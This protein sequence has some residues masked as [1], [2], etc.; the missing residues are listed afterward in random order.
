[1]FNPSLKFKFLAIFLTI[2]FISEIILLVLVSYVGHESLFETFFLNLLLLLMI[3]GVLGFIF[4]L[5]KYFNKSVEEIHSLTRQKEAL[6]L[7]ALVSETNCEGMITYVNE[8]FCKTSQYTEQELLGKS[9]NIIN[10]GTH[11]KEFWHDFWTS[12]KSGNVWNGDICNQAKDGSL[13]WVNATISP[14]YNSH[15]DLIGYSAIRIDITQSKLIDQQTKERRSQVSLYNRKLAEL[16]RHPDFI[17]NNFQ[18]MLSTL[19][20]MVSEVTLVSRVSVWKLHETLDGKSLEC[21]S[22][23]IRAEQEHSKGIEIK[24]SKYPKYFKAL[25]EN[26]TLSC[27][28]VYS[29]PRIEEFTEDYFPAFEITSMLDA[30]FHF[31]GEL[32]GVL[33]LEHTSSERKWKVEEEAF[34]ISVADI[35]SIIF[36]SSKR[37]D[38]EAALRHSEKL[39]ALGKLTGGIAH[40][41]N[42]LLGVIMGYSALLEESIKEHPRLLKYAHQINIASQRGSKLTKNLLSFSR[43]KD[44]EARQTDINLVLQNQMDMLQKTLT[45]R[46]NLDVDLMEDLWPVFLDRN[47]LENAILNISINSMHAM[48]DIGVDA[49]LMISTQNKVINS[50]EASSLELKPG[51]HVILTFND[52][53]LGMNKQ[54]ISKIFDPFFS[55]K[56][57]KGT[58]IG[59]SQVF[60]FIKRSSGTIKVTSQLGK[61][62]KFSLYF[63]RF[64]EQENELNEI[65]DDD[66]LQ[67]TGNESILVVDDEKALRL[68]MSE[69]LSQQGYDVFNAESASS[70]LKIIDE[71]D[72]KLVVTDI[73]MPKMDGYELAAELAETYPAIKIQL[74]SGFTTERHHEMV[75]DILQ[76][77]LLQKPYNSKILFRKI[78]ALLDS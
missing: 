76:D 41:F 44:S 14:I 77:N 65:E 37:Q 28:D 22:L 38:L 57:S 29:D 49:M 30:P 8:M 70:A 66:S 43:K 69:Q 52:N 62:S 13:Y 3:S 16:I 20:S 63:P 12:L 48:L 34:I 59:L 33:S 35:L 24:S 56:G 53:G 64:G 51:E 42:N 32:A 10:S 40:D 9:H 21:L 1:M 5:S 31:D 18:G 4:L 60:G 7:T 2:I 73:I 78:R 25:S 71:K 75:D 55:T 67:L 36:E 15:K 23:W 45:V 58:G 17:Q 6:D 11:S 19:T 46:I 74:V 47:D 54:T 50:D 26:R 27:D 72:I 39:E 61:G 68:L